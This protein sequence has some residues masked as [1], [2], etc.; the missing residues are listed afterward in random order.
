MY[1]ETETLLDPATAGSGD[2]STAKDSV[3][4]DAMESPSVAEILKELREIPD[5]ATRPDSGPRLDE[6]QVTTQTEHQA[7][8]NQAALAREANPDQKQRPAESGAAQPPQ[9]T[10]HHDPKRIR[11][12]RPSNVDAV[13]NMK[14]DSA[15]AFQVRKYWPS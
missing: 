3:Y 1:E 10:K 12:R 8:E 7:A 2:D 5:P 9:R 13:V 11:P 6:D 14:E 4:L 15:S